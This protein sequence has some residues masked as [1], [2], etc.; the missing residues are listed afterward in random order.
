MLKVTFDFETVDMLSKDDGPLDPSS[1]SA[2]NGAES[3]SDVT[4][5][6]D[7]QLPDDGGTLFRGGF[8]LWRSRTLFA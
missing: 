2:E 3:E 8:R 1:S 6:L 5:L 4:I 7:V